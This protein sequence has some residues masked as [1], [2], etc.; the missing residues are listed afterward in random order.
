LVE[1]LARLADAVW[2]EENWAG[3]DPGSFPLDDA[4]DFFDDTGVLAEPQGRIGFVLVDE[5]EVLA[6]ST[7]N[8]VLD[9]AIS[10]SALS[11]GEII[12]SGLWGDVVEAAQEALIVMGEVPKGN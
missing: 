8:S 10:T 12:H 1:W 3:N 4:L 11:D 2:Q 6:M 9:R 7:L 5:A